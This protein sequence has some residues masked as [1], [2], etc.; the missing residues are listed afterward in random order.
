MTAL[1][2]IQKHLTR[3]SRLLVYKSFI[4][5]VLEYGWQLYDNSGKVYISKLEKVQREALLAVTGA[6]RH[7]SHEKLLHEVGLTTLEK[8]R[9]A[10]KLKFIH[11]LTSGL[12]PN[13][14]SEL[15][16]NY[17]S[18]QSDYNLR[19]LKNLSLPRSKKKNFL[20]SFIP[21]SI[22]LWNKLPIDIRQ[23][24][25][26]DAFKLKITSIYGGLTNKIFLFGN[27]N[28]AINHSRIRMGLSGLNQQ[29]RK[30]NFIANSVCPKCNFKSEDAAHYFLHCPMYAAQRQKLLH[31]LSATPNSEIIYLLNSKAKKAHA[32]RLVN[33]LLFGTGNITI[34][35][36]IFECL[37][38]YIEDSNRF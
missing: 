21:S 4:R 3:D 28:G 35:K 24:D 23:L 31:T 30:Y 20:K 12:L 37:H 36:K 25:K 10:S 26:H 22:K 9:E 11:K 33:L 27:S 29:R 1:K 5:P 17:V 14:L 7:T 18:E 2:R 34:D 8:R 6:Y 16:P 19:N 38:V 13:Y 15:L 32:N